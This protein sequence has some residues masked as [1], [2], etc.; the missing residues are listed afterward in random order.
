MIEDHIIAQLLTSLVTSD[1][2]ATLTVSGI[3]TVTVP[4]IDL[5]GNDGDDGGVT[6]MCID[7]AKA[8][9]LG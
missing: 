6:S 8:S 7:L 3:A 2:P 9:V 4:V 1:L 5:G